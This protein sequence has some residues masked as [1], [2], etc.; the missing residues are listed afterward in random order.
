[1]IKLDIVSAED[2]SYYELWKSDSRL[3]GW[4]PRDFIRFCREWTAICKKIRRLAKEME[5]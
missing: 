4:T 3:H 5:G 1:M 2:H